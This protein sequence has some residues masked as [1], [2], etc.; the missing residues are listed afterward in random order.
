M[1]SKM[2]DIAETVM[3]YKQMESSIPGSSMLIEVRW[4]YADMAEGSDG[5]P[6][7]FVPEDWPGNCSPTCREY[8]YPN[9][10]D[11]FFQ[12]VRD[13]MGWK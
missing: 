4:Q 13:L 6:L 1:G 7:G 9:T 2:K 10:P 12:E 11:S 5:G 8:N 3:N